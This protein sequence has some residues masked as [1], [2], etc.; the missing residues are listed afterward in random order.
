MSMYSSVSM[1]PPCWS[2]EPLAE[3]LPDVRW[4]FLAIAAPST[5]TRPSRGSTR[6]TRPV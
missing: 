6:I 2:W 1:I 4:C 5:I 3:R